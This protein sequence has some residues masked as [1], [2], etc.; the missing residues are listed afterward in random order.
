MTEQTREINILKQCASEFEAFCARNDIPCSILRYDY[1]INVYL[2][3]HGADYNDGMIMS[4]KMQ[5]LADPSVDLNMIN[6]LVMDQIFLQPE[7][8]YELTLSSR[9]DE[10]YLRTFE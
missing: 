7:Y 10:S 8:E 3:R 6:G 5:W 9:K 2:L 1:Y 4:Y